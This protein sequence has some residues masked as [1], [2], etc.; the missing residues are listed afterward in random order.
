MKIA[1]V[2]NQNLAR[3]RV[4]AAFFTGLLE[5]HNFFSFGVIAVE[6]R[7]NPRIINLIFEKWGLPGIKD[8]AQ[9][10]VS[11][12]GELLAC[13]IVFTVSDFVYSYIGD[14]GFKGKLINLELTALN[15]GINLTDPQ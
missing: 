9:N 15:L 13:D 6:G 5:E 14:L 12:L 11:H 1:F 2:C 7:Q 10:V 8:S 4:L 3:S